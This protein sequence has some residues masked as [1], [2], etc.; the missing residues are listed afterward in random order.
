[1]GF[2]CT[3]LKIDSDLIKIHFWQEFFLAHSTVFL[4]MFFFKIDLD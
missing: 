2:L 4:C 1:M 3:V